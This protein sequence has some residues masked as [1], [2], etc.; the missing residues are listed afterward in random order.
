[1]T[2][3]ALQST[4]PVTGYSDLPASEPENQSFFIPLQASYP[5]WF[6]QTEQFPGEVFSIYM[7]VVFTQVALD[8]PWKAAL[9]STNQDSD[10]YRQMSQI[11]RDS[12]GYATG[13]PV[14]DSALAMAPAPLPAT[15]ANLY[16]SGITAANDSQLIQPNSIYYYRY[17]QDLGVRNGPAHGF[18]ESAGQTPGNLPV[19]ALALTS[20]GAEVIFTTINTVNY[21]ATRTAAITSDFDLG[22]GV[23]EPPWF[24]HDFTVPAGTRMSQVTTFVLVATDPVRAK[25]HVEVIAADQV[26]ATFSPATEYAAT[27]GL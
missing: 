15:W 20:G 2:G 22:S 12:Q 6:V 10:P 25:G 13:L 4:V 16:N 21:L 18:V 17:L 9:L 24:Q 8:Q 14:A 5:R 11:A 23:P 19:Y 3:E 7:M 1:M 27:H 26:Q